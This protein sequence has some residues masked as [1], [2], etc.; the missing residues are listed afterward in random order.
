MIEVSKEKMKHW[1]VGLKLEDIAEAYRK[2]NR[3]ESNCFIFFDAYTIPLNISDMRLVDDTLHVTLNAIK[4][5]PKNVYK[6]EVVNGDLIAYLGSDEAER[7]VNLG[8]V[9]GDN[10]ISPRFTIENGHLFADYDH[11]Y[12]G[13]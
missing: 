8:R 3:L 13:E 10:G 4:D 6:V 5:L 7:T 11:P 9:T 2:G 12:N 1:N